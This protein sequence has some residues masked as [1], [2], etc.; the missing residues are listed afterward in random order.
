MDPTSRALVSR[1]VQEFMALRRVAACNTLHHITSHHAAGNSE[2][3]VLIVGNKYEYGSCVLL[4]VSQSAG[5][6]SIN[7]P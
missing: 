4:V 5:T 6:V 7:L 2:T 1:T 3:R